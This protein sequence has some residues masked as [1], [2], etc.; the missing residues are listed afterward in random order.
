[1]NG[2]Q[3]ETKTL[4]SAVTLEVAHAQD[5]KFPNEVTA[6]RGAPMRIV[7]IDPDTFYVSPTPDSNTT[8]DAKM[9]LAL[10][11]VRDAT[12]MD[13][14]VLDDLETVIMHGA[15]QHLLVL[16]ERTWT[17]RELAAYHAKQYAFKSAERRARVNVGSGRAVLTAQMR[18]LA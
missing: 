10:K 3:P 5:P 14:G 18:P 17:D 15:L 9:I 2:R 6:E 4:A 13:K 11:P 8:Y 7:H 16:P 1:M 12:G